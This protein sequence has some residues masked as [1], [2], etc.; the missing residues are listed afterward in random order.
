MIVGAAVAVKLAGPVAPAETDPR[1]LVLIMA[2]VIV[3][4]GAGPWHSEDSQP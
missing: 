1:H 2:G 4:A 3:G